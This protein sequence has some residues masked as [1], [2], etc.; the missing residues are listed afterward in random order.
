MAPNLTSGNFRIVS[1]VE[2]NPLASVNHTRPGV[3]DVVLGGPVTKVSQYFVFIWNARLT[4]SAVVGNQE[5]FR[6]YLSVPRGR[7][8]VHRG[9]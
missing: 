6:R 3:Q 4:L 5:R 7:I 8:S 9:S 2:G 1:L